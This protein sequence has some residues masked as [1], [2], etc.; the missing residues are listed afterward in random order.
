MRTWLK[1]VAW[2]AGIVAAIGLFLRLFFEVWTVPT[3]DPL[4]A[5]SI[6]PTLAAGDVVV[7]TRHPSI[8][9]GNLLRCTD[10]D[11]PGRFVV[12]RAIGS[13]GDRLGLKDEFVTIDGKRTPSPRLCET[14]VVTVHDPRGD[15]VVSLTCSVEEYGDVTFNALRSPE[16]PEGVT[17]ATVEPARWFLVSDNRHFHLDSRDYGQ[18]AASACQHVVFRIVGASGFWDARKRLSIIW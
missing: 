12:A 5:A 6:E 7:V 8:D 15:D 14:S 11:A 3:D 16:R 1:I 9:R 18:M 2:A 17:E 4:L 13:F 10:P